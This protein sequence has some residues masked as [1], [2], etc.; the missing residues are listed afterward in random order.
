[1]FVESQSVRPLVVALGNEFHR[2][3]VVK[4]E[5]SDT[6]IFTRAAKFS[7]T[8]IHVRSVTCVMIAG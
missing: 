1:M 2:P 8:Q 5:E 4:R 3:Y 7:S 6:F